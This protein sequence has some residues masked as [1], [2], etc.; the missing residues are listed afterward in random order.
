M[1]KE[2]LNQK[3]RERY[4]QSIENINTDIFQSN[5]RKLWAITAANDFDDADELQ[6]VIEQSQEAIDYFIALHNENI[7]R[8]Q[9]LRQEEKQATREHKVVDFK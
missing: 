2:F 8:L 7:E 9:Q 6:C 5:Q 3:K 4:F 1:I